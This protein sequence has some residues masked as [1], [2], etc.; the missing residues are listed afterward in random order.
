MSLTGIINN[1]EKFRYEG[2]EIYAFKS[3]PDRFLCFFFE[4]K[5]IIVTNGFEK[6]QDKLPLTEKRRALNFKLDYEKRCK[7]G[8]YYE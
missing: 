6:K 1:I 8:N 5:K 2:D 4:G 3:Q 7:E